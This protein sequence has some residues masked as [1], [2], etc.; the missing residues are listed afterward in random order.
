VSPL[1]GRDFLVIAD[2]S[3][4]E[5]RQVLDLAQGSP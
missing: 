1:G 3:A 4:G 2:L 5:L